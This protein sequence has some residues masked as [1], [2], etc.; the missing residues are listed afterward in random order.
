MIILQRHYSFLCKLY[1]LAQ[2]NSF[3]FRN[4]VTALLLE[5]RCHVIVHFIKSITNQLAT[6]SL[7]DVMWLHYSSLR[8]HVIAYFIISLT[9]QLY[10]FILRCHVTA[11]PLFTMSCN[12]ILYNLV[13]QY[14]WQ[15]LFTM[16]RD[17][18]TPLYNVKHYSLYNIMWLYALLS[19][20]LQLLHILKMSGDCTTT[21]QCHL[22]VQIIISTMQLPTP[23]HYSNAVWLHS[24][25]LR[26]HVNDV[27]VHFIYVLSILQNNYSFTLRCNVT[28]FLLFTVSSDA[29]FT[30]SLTTQLLPHLAIVTALLLFKMSCDCKLYISYNATPSLS[31]S[32]DCIN[33]S[34]FT[35][36]CDSALHILV[37]YNSFTLQ[38]HVTAFLL[39]TSCYISYNTT[40]SL[41]DVM[42]LLHSSFEFH[43]IVHSIQLLYF[44]KTADWK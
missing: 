30:I 29:Y 31:M 16:S 4:H 37:Q 12:C 2:C 9:I 40:H 13:V 20:T 38:C 35:I 6:P 28:V 42:R 39:M 8:C 41:Y 10:S 18:T 34:S 19:C 36:S 5:I 11:L 17:C 33:Y 26:Y 22:M 7:C 43:V 21:L 24:F 1:N 23:S 3:T 44:I 15:L 32:C 27:I 14:N 25:S